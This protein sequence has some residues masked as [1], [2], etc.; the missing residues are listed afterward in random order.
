M[1]S[2]YHKAENEFCII[3]PRS[4][5]KACEAAESFSREIEEVRIN[6][7]AKAGRQPASQPKK[8]V[9]DRGVICYT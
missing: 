4:T 6:K 7:G 8:K 3:R 1:D 5:E 9:M 2:F